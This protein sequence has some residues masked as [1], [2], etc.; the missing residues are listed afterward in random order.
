MI[1]GESMENK[2]LVLFCTYKI[3]PAIMSEFAKMQNC[4]VECVLG[5]NNSN[6]IVQDEDMR[7]GGDYTD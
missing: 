5:I 3:T 2:T 6:H 4:G 1:L 7:G